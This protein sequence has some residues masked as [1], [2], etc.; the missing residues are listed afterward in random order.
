MVKNDDAPMVK[1][2]FNDGNETVWAQQVGDH[3]YRIDNAP[4]YTYQVS[5]N[6]IVHAEQVEDAAPGF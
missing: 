5:C 1:I 6:D 3:L 4:F 2:L